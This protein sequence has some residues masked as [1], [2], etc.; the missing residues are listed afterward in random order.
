MLWEK[1][2][3]KLPD[4][5]A[6]RV[7]EV[8]ELVHD[9]GADVVKPHFAAEK[10]VKEDLRDHHAN[11]GIGVLPSISGDQ[12]DLIALEA[13]SFRLVLEF[14][15]LL[16]GKRY[17]R[18]RVVEAL[19][20]VQGFKDGR[21]GDEC[22]AHPRRGGDQHSAFGLVPGEQG[23][24]L[25]RVQIILDPIEKTVADLRAVHVTYDSI[26]V[27]RKSMSLEA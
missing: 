4:N 16:V 9:H 19:P 26:E 13:P 5:A 8:V 18:R 20:G 6:L 24:L 10:M 25:E 27:G 17:K 1:R 15:E 22:F 14:A 12:P 7:V 21:L 2:Q 23:V 11:M 3:C